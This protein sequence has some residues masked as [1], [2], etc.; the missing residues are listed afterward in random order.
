MFRDFEAGGERRRGM[1]IYWD[2][3]GN[4]SGYVMAFRGVV[5][6]YDSS[7]SWSQ[8]DRSCCTMAIL[9]NHSYCMYALMIQVMGEELLKLF[10]RLLVRCVQRTSREQFIFILV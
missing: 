3:W 2:F 8:I 7:C 5:W 9:P 4:G 10:L 6:I 1:G